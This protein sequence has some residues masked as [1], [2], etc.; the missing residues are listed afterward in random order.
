MNPARS[1]GPAIF[2]GGLSL[3]VLWIYFAG[4]V[5][6]AVLAVLCAY[7]LGPVPN[8]KEEEVATGKGVAIET[9]E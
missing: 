1:L 3:H 6:G 8:P 2:A 5:I 9:E 7:G 4:P